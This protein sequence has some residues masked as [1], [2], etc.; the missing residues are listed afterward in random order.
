[1]VLNHMIR[2]MPFGY[3]TQGSA[4]WLIC[5]FVIWILNIVQK[6]DRGD[7]YLNGS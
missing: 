2:L 6:L 4:L 1:M 3:V 5:V 7:Q